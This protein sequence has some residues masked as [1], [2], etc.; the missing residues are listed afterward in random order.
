MKEIGCK[1]NYMGQVYWFGLMA[2]NMKENFK[3]I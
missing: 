1:I 3:I 2:G